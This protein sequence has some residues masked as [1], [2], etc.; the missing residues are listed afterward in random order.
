[1]KELDKG[2]IAVLGAGTMGAGIAAV[3]AASGFRVALY[4][5][6][7]KTLEKA[8]NTIIDIFE[9]FK[10]EKMYDLPIWEIENDRILY[11]TQIEAAVD[12]AFYVV[13]TVI[14]KPEIKREVYR[15]LDGLL[16]SDTIISSN[17]SYMNIFDFMPQERQEKLV[18]VHWVAPPHILPL[19]EVVKGPGTSEQTMDAMMTLH[20]GCGKTPVRMEKYIP[21]FILNRLQSAMTREVVGL[22]QD[23]YCTPEMIDKA[24]KTSLMPRGLL[25]GVVQRMDFNGIDQVSHGLNNKSFVPFGAP[26]EH[27]IITDMAERGEKGIK[28]GVGF[29][30]Y[31]G[32]GSEVAIQQRDKLLIQS[33]KLS[34]YFM[35]NPI[36]EERNWEN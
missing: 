1:M 23:G 20:E 31:S 4:S 13:E 3:Y 15:E 16:P 34:K 10:N 27:N 14:E 7:E 18:I 24:V 26:P 2:K 5:R 12:K 33:V 35:D 32:I 17:T 25:L 29:R 30:D 8:K 36:G 21:G 19:V 28:T 9:L 6:T 11:T 22:L